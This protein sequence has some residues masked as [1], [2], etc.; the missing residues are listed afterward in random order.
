MDPTDR[1]NFNSVLKICSNQYI[2]G[3]EKHVPG[4]DATR[5]YLTCMENILQAALEKDL[6]IEGRIYRMFNPLHFL[7]Y[8]IEWLE[9]SEVHKATLNF[10]TQNTYE[11]I[12]LNGQALL[13]TIL[14]CLEAGSFENFLPW[15]MGS[16]PCES[17]FR[18]FRSQGTVYSMIV[19]FTVL[20]PLYKL[21]KMR[22]QQNIMGFNSAAEGIKITFPR[23]KFLYASFECHDFKDKNLNNET[24]GQLTLAGVRAIMDK[25]KADAFDSA[26]HSQMDVPFEAGN[27]L[28]IIQLG[29][30]PAKSLQSYWEG[31]AGLRQQ[32]ILMEQKKLF[33]KKQSS[34]CS[35]RAYPESAVIDYNA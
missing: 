28:E 12:E 22:K 1:M 23:N 30:A 32:R 31:Y 3:L 10:I 14:R 19:N 35:G 6:S 4:S 16:Q 11:C 26:R 7:R 13:K 25:A 24:T 2:Q 33:W 17:L 5:M 20:D 27:R 9:E 29:M 21:C 34:G 18:V 8:W 15:L